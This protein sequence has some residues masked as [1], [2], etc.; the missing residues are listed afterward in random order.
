MNINTAVAEQ[1]G[2]PPSAYGLVFIGANGWVYPVRQN[3]EIGICLTPAHCP[4]RC[5]NTVPI[6]SAAIRLKKDSEVLLNEFL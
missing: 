1:P 4:F 2:T 3:N 6:M 5:I